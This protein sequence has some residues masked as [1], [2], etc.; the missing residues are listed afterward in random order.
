MNG[1][2]INQI[3]SKKMGIA[4]ITLIALMKVQAPPYCLMLVGVATIIVQG[5]LDL[6]KGDKNEKSNNSN[7][8]AGD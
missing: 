8:P 2:D 5:L 3:L 1:I 6:K 4:I 7:V